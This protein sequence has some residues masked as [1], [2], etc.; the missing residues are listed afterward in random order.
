M[1]QLSNSVIARILDQHNIRHYTENGR[2]YGLAFYT[3]RNGGSGYEVDDLTGSTV[4]ELR[5]WLGY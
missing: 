5:F 2:I 4:E 3:T 1:R